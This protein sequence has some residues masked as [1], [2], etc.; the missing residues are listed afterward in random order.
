MAETIK[1]GVIKKKTD[2]NNSVILYPKTTS[3]MIEYES[4]TYTGLIG[5]VNEFRNA[6]F[7]FLNVKPASWN[8][9]WRIRYRIE[10]SLDS[11]LTPSNYA[12]YTSIHD[13]EIIGAR[14]ITSAYA[15][16]NGINN[17][18]YRTVFYNITH[19]TTE[20]GFNNNYPHKIGIE[21]TSSSN[22]TNTNYKRTIKITLL[23]YD[24]CEVTFNDTPE[25]PAQATRSDYTKINSTYYPN[26]A[27][28]NT[29]GYAYRGNLYSNGLQEIGDD[30]TTDRLYYHNQ[31]M[32]SGSTMGLSGYNMYGLDS[33]NKI[34]PISLYQSGYTSYTTNISTAR[35][36]NTAGFDWTRGLFR[37][38]SS[39][40]IA[41]GTT[42]TLIHADK[43]NQFD[44]RYTDNCLSTA[45]TTLS[46]VRNKFVYLRGTI[47]SDGLFYLAPIE[48]TYNSSTYKRA[49]TQ[50][51]PTT[52]DG[53][54]YW[55]I[56]HPYSTDS[57]QLRLYAENSLY[58]YKD[59]KFREYGPQPI[60]IIDLR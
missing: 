30:N 37:Y 16:F 51:I 56:G 53:Y 14:G 45:G 34:Q 11:G 40:F 44:Y 23:S 21:L 25:I 38:L 9:E 17:T 33:E 27:D 19:C 59:G 31:Y 49:W 29:P 35:V 12:L 42:D 6:T 52:E 28:S 24:G 10:A 13:C 54:V 15:Y 58:W 18:S 47:G 3:D 8:K 7:Y 1:K 43:V 50:D 22:P 20:T 57:Y 2:E 5:T 60:K 39:G 55:L 36:Y 41:A 4:K 26:Q 46:F 48:V 32:D